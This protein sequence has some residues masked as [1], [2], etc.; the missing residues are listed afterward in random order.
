MIDLHPNGDFQII[1]ILKRP[2]SKI[3]FLPS[4]KKT[5]HNNVFYNHNR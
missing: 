1:E 4:K 2:T 3:S 5:F